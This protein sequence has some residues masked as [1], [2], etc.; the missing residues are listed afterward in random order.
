VA[1]HLDLEIFNV[2]AP[3]FEFSGV[4]GKAGTEKMLAIWVVK[5]SERPGSITFKY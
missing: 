4:G 2:S 1:K 3:D 5:R